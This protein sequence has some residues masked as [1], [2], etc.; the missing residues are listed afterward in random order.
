M[1]YTHL[2]QGKWNSR[3]KFKIIKLK[4]KMKIVIL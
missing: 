2:K 3:M 1:K 4:V